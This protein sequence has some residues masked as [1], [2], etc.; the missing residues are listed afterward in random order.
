MKN[1]LKLSSLIIGFLFITTNCF[2]L[3]D[4]DTVFEWR[5]T[6]TADTL[7]GGGFNSTNATPGTDLSTYDSAAAI[8][9]AYPSSGKFSGTN[10]VVD[11]GDANPGVISSA[12]HNFVAADCGN[13]IHITAGTSW[14]ASWYEIVST[15]GNKATLDRDVSATNGQLTG[16][17]WY[18]GGALNV[19]GAGTALEDDFFE[20]IKGTTGADGITVYFYNNNSTSTVVFTLGEQINVT[21]ASADTINPAKIIGYKQTRGDNPTGNSRPT[22]AAGSS[23]VNFGIANVSNLILTGTASPAYNISPGKTINCKVVNSSTTVDRAAFSGTSANRTIYN[24]EGISYRGRGVVLGHSVN[25]FFSYFHDSDTGIWVSSALQELSVIGNISESNVTYA[26]NISEG[27]D[28]NGLFVGNTLYGSEQK[29]GTGINIATN[30]AYLTFTNNIIY[31]FVTG[32]TAADAVQTGS[33]FDYND[34]YN[35]TTPRTNVMTGTNDQA[36]DPT[37]TSVAQV[38]GSTA[39]YVGSTLTQAGV[40]FSNVV[41][42]QDFVYIA[43]GTGMTYAPGC[44]KITSHTTTT[45][46]TDVDVGENAEG[47]GDDNVTFQV[48]TGRNFAIGTNLKAKGFPGAFQ[49]ALTTGYLDIGAVQRQEPAAGGGVGSI[50][51]STDF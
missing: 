39:F 8:E 15:S 6:A 3:L 50:S 14:T 32:A 43:S 36:L 51:T 47:G 11:D 25:V 16:G 26:L 34:Y 40:D 46:T 9:A 23:A 38:K 27:L 4:A 45:I 30:A 33:Y 7:N 18:L 2:A 17:T 10:L 13:I 42:N 41:D 44:Y 1:F 19:K 28:A 22:I 12:T 35:N 20:V 21:T 49:G 29:T 37:F 31:G 48:T 24:C 5:S